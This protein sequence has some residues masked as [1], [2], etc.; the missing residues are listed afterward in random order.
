M[1]VGKEKLPEDR[2]ILS[3][4]LTTTPDGVKSTSSRIGMKS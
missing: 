3:H 2:S 1:K 4:S